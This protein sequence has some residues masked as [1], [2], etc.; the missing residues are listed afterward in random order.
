MPRNKF[1]AVIFGVIMSYSMAF[2][3]E[4]FNTAINMGIPFQGGGFSHMTWEA[5]GSA[6]KEMLIMGVFVFILSNLIGNKAGSK[7]M[8]AHTT[9]A[10]NPYFRQ[11]MRQAGTVSVMC[12]AMSLLATVLFFTIG[13]HQQISQIPV[14]WIGTVLKNFS[15][16]F[17]WN[18][19]AAAPFSRW[20]FSVLFPGKTDNK[21]VIPEIPG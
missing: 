4:L 13:Q 15:M 19:F 16:A 17:F 5:V 7:F 2:G 14:T 20:L 10:D 11:L 9:K 1:Q 21:I 18:M 3:M 6:M 12:P 8:E